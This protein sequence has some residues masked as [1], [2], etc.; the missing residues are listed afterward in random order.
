M[1][2]YKR[3][4]KHKREDRW[5]V[6]TC[7]HGKVTRLYSDPVTHKAFLSHDDAKRAE[8]QLELEVQTD[9]HPKRVKTKVGDLKDL[10]LIS[11][12]KKDKATTVYNREICLKNWVGPCLDHFYVEDLTND[13]LDRINDDLN[14]RAPK[15][16]MN[17]IVSTARGF[18]KFLRKWNGTLLPERIFEYLNSE[19]SNHVYHFYSFEQE[20]KFLSVITNPKD[21]LLF[22]LFCYYG[23]RMTECLALKRGDIDLENKTISIKRIISRKTDFAEPIFTTPKTKRSIRTLTL[24]PGIAELLPANLGPDDFLFPGTWDSIVMGEVVVR[25]KAKK[26]AKLAGLPPIKVHEFRHSCASNLIKEGIPL[27]IVARWLGDTEGTV[28]SYYS[29]LFPDE[30]NSVGTYFTA[31][32]LGVPTE[33][34]SGGNGPCSDQENA[35]EKEE[36]GQAAK[37][38]S[39]DG[40]EM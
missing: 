15:A 32:P 31:H 19:P 13:D 30:E 36:T 20:D 14:H 6:Q 18:I 3:P 25:R 29:H 27:R 24:I 9:S 1:S 40:P 28:L 35:P 16:S 21:K 22:T 26:Y 11:L 2:I 34:K 7:R 37:N 23:F 10:Y 8:T 5:V 33:P 4:G 12:R 38:A 17:T 39:D